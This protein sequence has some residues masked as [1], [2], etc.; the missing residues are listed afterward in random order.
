MGG[1]GR[2]SGHR[3]KETDGVTKDGT[4]ITALHFENGAEVEAKMFIDATYAKLPERL[5]A[6]KQVLAVPASE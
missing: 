5:L 2:G 3:L 1:L 4:R 6:D